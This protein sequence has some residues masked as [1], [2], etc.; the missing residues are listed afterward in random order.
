MARAFPAT[1]K[2]RD[3]SGDYGLHTED[4][5]TTHLSRGMRSRLP[6]ACLMLPARHA[7]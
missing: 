3:A 6:G 2:A 7:A 1:W 5:L 4:C